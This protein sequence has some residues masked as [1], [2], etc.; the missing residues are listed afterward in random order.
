M[1]RITSIASAGHALV[2]ILSCPGN[3]MRPIL[4]SL[5]VAAEQAYFARSQMVE[6]SW[7]TY[8]CAQKFILF[9]P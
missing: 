1:F 6:M 2:I 4:V 7:A 8:N 9:A 3:M 5:P